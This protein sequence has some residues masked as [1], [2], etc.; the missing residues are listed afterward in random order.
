MSGIAQIASLE[1]A[2]DDGERDLWRGL[3][4]R[5]KDVIPLRPDRLRVFDR[6]GVFCAGSSRRKN[7]DILPPAGLVDRRDAIRIRVDLSLPEDLSGLLIE[8]VHE[9][10]RARA[11]ED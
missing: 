2:T 9:S 3:A 8:R 1:S 7:R 5:G 4:G 10:V 6:Q 11:D